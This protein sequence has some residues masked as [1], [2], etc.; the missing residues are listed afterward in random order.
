[1]FHKNQIT[2]KVKGKGPEALNFCRTEAL[3]WYLWW[4]I[5][6]APAFANSQ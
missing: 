5:S 2:L 3:H 4:N 6:E 1:M